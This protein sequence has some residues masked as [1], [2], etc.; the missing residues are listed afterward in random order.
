MNYI[1]A[2]LR[3]GLGNVLFKVAAAISLAIDNNVYCLFSNEFVGNNDLRKIDYK[4]YSDNILRNLQLTSNIPTPYDIYTEPYYHHKTIQYKKDTN[5][6]ISG[7]F[8]SEKYFTGNKQS[9]I[10]SFSAPQHIRKH[11]S[12]AIPTIQNYTSIHVR[13]GDYVYLQQYH[14]LT[15]KEF[16][17][18]A[19]DL[20]GMRE[21]YLVFSDDPESCH[22]LLDFLPNKVIYTTGV[23]WMDLYVMSMCGNNIIANSTFS[24]WSAYLNENINKT[25][26]APLQWFGPAYADLDTKDLIPVNWIRI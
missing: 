14:P 8:Q 17:Q 12:E 19:V 18:R 10:D 1:S 6:L 13:R 26:I 25:V 24:W 7:D 5:L 22:E 3:G 9:I 4:V 2:N 15:T 16:Y 20:I 23:D 21:N 11:I